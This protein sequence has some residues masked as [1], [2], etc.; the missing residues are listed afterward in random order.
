MAGQKNPD[1]E[2]LFGVA[3]GGSVDGESGKLIK[4]QLESIISSINS[5]PMPIKVEID[6][7]SIKAIKQE[8]QKV[9]DAAKVSVK[10]SKSAATSNSSNTKSEP[11]KPKGSNSQAKAI[12]ADSAEAQNA[13]TKIN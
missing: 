9:T 11:V 10:V 2:L 4:E 7:S 5:K 1:V 8:L 3:G 6:D 13:I 12:K